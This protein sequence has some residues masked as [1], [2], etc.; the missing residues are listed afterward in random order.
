MREKSTILGSATIIL[1]LLFSAVAVLMPSTTS[2]EQ[3]T[4][5][6]LTHAV[7]AENAGSAG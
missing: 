6:P 2:S 3:A 1:T 7:F 4:L 5:N